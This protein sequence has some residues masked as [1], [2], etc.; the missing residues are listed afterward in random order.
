V[1]A[2]A[3]TS[4]HDLPPVAGWWNGADIEEKHALGHLDDAA[5]KAA[6]AERQADRQ[7]LVAAIAAAGVA[8][9]PPID[10]AARH[11]P[12]VTAAIHRYACASPSALLLIQADDLAG[13]TSMLNVPG[14]DRER[15]NWRRKIAVEASALWQTPVGR[16]AAR[17]FAARKPDGSTQD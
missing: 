14:T 2:A 13:E 9:A 1:K 3:C 7:A 17:D 6:G 15:A 12:A 16:D 8:P 5:A 10:P 11:T 4:T